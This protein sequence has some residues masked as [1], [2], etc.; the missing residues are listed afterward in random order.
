M[1]TAQREREQQREVAAQRQLAV[2]C[3]LPCGRRWELLGLASG[4]PKC[5]PASRLATS[6]SPASDRDTDLDRLLEELEEDATSPL[7]FG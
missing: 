3:F 5:A 7:Y 2:A 1:E 6:S 4:L